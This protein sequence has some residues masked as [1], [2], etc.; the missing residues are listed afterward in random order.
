MAITATRDALHL[1]SLSRRRVVE[2][3]VFHAL[4]LEKQPPPLVRFLAHLPRAHCATWTVLDSGPA[5]ER[6]PDLP[7]VRYGRA[8]APARIAEDR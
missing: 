8:L 1:V 2:P 5:G 6:L 7:R 3:Q 4:A